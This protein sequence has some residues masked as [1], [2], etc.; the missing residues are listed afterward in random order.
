MAWC[1]PAKET[2][3]RLDLGSLR[4]ACH[5]LPVMGTRPTCHCAIV[6]N[7]GRHVH[8]AAINVQ[9][10]HAADKVLVGHGEVLGEVGDTPQKQGARQVQGPGGQGSGSLV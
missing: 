8:S 5:P 1:L 6:C 10:P 7:K 3:V 4:V 2:G 9:V